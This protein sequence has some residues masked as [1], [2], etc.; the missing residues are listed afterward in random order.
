VPIPCD[1]CPTGDT[2][3]A[4]VE[5]LFD[6]T[7][8]LVSN[9]TATGVYPLTRWSDGDVS[10][11]NFTGFNSPGVDF[12]AATSPVIELNFATPQ[13][14][15]RGL[16]EWNQGG[17]DL[18]D[19]DGFASW[20]FE[21]FAG[22]TS[23][24]TGN[25]IMGN[26]GAPFSFLLPGGQELNGVTRVRLSNMRK[27]NPGAG[28]SPLTREVR[29][30][31]YQ[32]VIP[33]RRNSG[34]LEWYD[35]AGNLIPSSEVL[36]CATNQPPVPGQSVLQPFAIPDLHFLGGFFNDAPGENLCSLTPAPIANSGWAAPSSGCYDPTTANP[37]MDWGPTQSLDFTYGGPNTSGAVS[38]NFTSPTYGAITWPANAANMVVGEQRWSNVFGGGI[39]ARMTYVSG[40]AASM[41]MNGGTV[42]TIHQGGGIVVTANRFKLEFFTQ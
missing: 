1:C 9:G 10:G 2:R 23:L 19:A 20:D 42:L 17:N 14:R 36:D 27:L 30:L 40:S 33:C 39:L 18:G 32:T 41:L 5:Q 4:L 38:A 29:A 37:T 13:N 26:G 3:C 21:F 22:A 24:T 12:T 11:P 28:V 25:M 31:A 6:G 35:Q 8:V 34:A 7:T 15:I 16:R